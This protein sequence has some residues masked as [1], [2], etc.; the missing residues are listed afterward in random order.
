M[1]AGY[2]RLDRVGLKSVFASSSP[3]Y[4]VILSNHAVKSL[5]SNVHTPSVTFGEKFT[6]VPLKNGET[7]S[8]RIVIDGTGAETTLSIRD[9]REAEGYQ[10]AYGVEC[11]VSGPGVTSKAAGSYR[12]D[13]MTLFDYRTDWESDEARLKALSDFPTFMY[14]MPLGG[15]KMFFEETSL[16][17]NP[18][19]SFAECKRRCTDRLKS[20]GVNI[21]KV[22]EEE[23]CYIPMGGEVTRRGQRIVPI[24][25]AAGVVHPSTGYQICR[26]L[27]ANLD[28]SRAI[29]EELDKPESSFS[30]DLSSAVINDKLWTAEAIRQR[31][32]A[33]FG[34]DFLMNQDVSGLQ[35]FFSGFFRLPF[36]MWAGF[37][38]GMKNLPNNEKHDTWY[39]RMFFGVTFLTKLPPK[40]GLA[41]TL[42]IVG[43]FK[44]GLDLFQSVLP[45]F[46]S[47]P[48]F[49]SACDF[50]LNN[51]DVAVKE[52]AAKMIFATGDDPEKFAYLKN[53][54]EEESS[55]A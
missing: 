43:T 47:P 3:A 54:E 2:L 8:G 51:G 42:S 29:A 40:V 36:P 45:L 5:A 21:G 13:R 14:V 17:A 10:V 30:P 37:L 18:A 32:F 25:A 34:G 46:G 44:D 26:T 4:D 38:A 49:K 12:K 31:N 50:A 23:F 1:G 11:D 55:N 20:M 52:E 27:S 35:G 33:V 7:V 53:E 24:G 22:Y 6:T 15:D 28:V 48:S 19:I 39:A 16:V 41:L 9:G